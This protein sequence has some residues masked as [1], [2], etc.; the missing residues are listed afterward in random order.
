MPFGAQVVELV[1]QHLRVDHDAV[2]DRAQLARVEDPG[3]DQ[4]ELPL[5]AVADDRVAGVVAA[6]EADHEVRVLGEQ[7]DDL[8]LALVAPLGADDHDAGHVVRAVYEASAAAAAR[9]AVAPASLVVPAAAELRARLVRTRAAGRC[10]YMRQRVAAHLVQPRDRALADLLAQLV[11]GARF[12]VSSDRAA[13]LVA[14]V[15]DRVELLEHPRRALLGADV[16]D[17]QQV[18]GGEAVEQ[19][20]EASTRD[21]VVERLAQQ[22]EQPRQRVDRDRAVGLHRAPCEI[23]IASVV[24]PVPTSPVNQMPAAVVELLADRRAT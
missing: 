24:L 10:P 14:R 13:V 16:V 19:L 17:V 18:D 2:A 20:V 11:V 7:V 5:H 1:G 9:L 4:V 21:V 8:A 23:S 15:D 12:V 22:A 6:L 3:R